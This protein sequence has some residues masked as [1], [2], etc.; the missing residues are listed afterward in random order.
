VY[1][2]TDGGTTWQNLSNGL[3]DKVLLGLALDP[4]N[5]QILFAGSA[6]RGIYKSEDGGKT[7]RSSSAGM[8]PNEQIS[9][10]VVDPM[11]SNV[12][13]AGSWK[14]GV[15]ISEDGGKTWRLIKDGLSTRSVRALAISADGNHLYAVTRG[16]GVFRL[17]RNGQPPPTVFNPQ[18]VPTTQAS[19][20]TTQSV[21]DPQKTPSFKIPSCSG[22]LL[23]ILATIGWR[24]TNGSRKFLHQ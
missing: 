21:A 24:V 9:S 14:S 16:E 20:G 1:F 8:D 12:V 10:I 2:T 5:P 15:F 3:S 11:R 13:Y 17:D 19:N 22:F 23:L 4:N 18:I 7:W 6:Y